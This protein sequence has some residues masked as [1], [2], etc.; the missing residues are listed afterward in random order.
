M[1]PGVIVH[2]TCSRSHSRQAAELEYKLS[3]PDSST[4]TLNPCALCLSA[5]GSHVTAVLP[6]ETGSG[7]QAPIQLQNQTQ[8]HMV[9]N[10]RLLYTDPT[11]TCQADCFLP[12]NCLSVRATFYSSHEPQRM[13]ALLTC[14]IIH[15]VT[16]FR[17]LDH[18]IRF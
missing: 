17:D 8:G 12:M 10:Q 14:E 13:L 9:N 5:Q 18:V 1:V 6:Q 4:H 7:V 11:L 16:K 15:K 3:P 2:F